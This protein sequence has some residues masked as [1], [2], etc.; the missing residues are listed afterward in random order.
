[1]EP[2]PWYQSHSMACDMHGAHEQRASMRS[3]VASAHSCVPSVLVWWVQEKDAEVSSL[4]AAM[5]EK[6]EAARVRS[7]GHS[8]TR[9][10]GHSVISRCDSM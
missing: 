3:M 4:L 1:M 9:Q 2:I 7:D 5:A 8:G 6:V 10:P